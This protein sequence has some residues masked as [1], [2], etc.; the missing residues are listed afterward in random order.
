MFS[1]ISSREQAMLHFAYLYCTK[2]TS[3]VGFL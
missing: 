2:P 3:Q 1:A